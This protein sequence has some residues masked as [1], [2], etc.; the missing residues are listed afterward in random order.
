M[1]S[2]VGISILCKRLNYKPFISTIKC[3][4][5]LYMAILASSCTSVELAQLSV[6]E[7]AEAYYRHIY[8]DVDLSESEDTAQLIDRFISKL[9]RYDLQ[10]IDLNHQQSAEINGRQ[11]TALLR[12]DELERYLKPGEHRQRYGR[13]SLTQ[14]RGRKKDE[15]TVITFRVTFIDQPSG[16]TMFQ[17]DY[18]AEGQW[19]SDSATV[20][21]ALAGSLSKRLEHM[22]YIA[23]KN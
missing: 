1:I 7:S 16:Q 15:R 14:M 19:Y 12:V 20:A 11:G 4:V 9:S 22:D 13:A 3:T 23:E 17:A 2:E 10:V 21:S 5:I 8:L 6:D 18:V